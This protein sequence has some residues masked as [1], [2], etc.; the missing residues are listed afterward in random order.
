MGRGLFILMSLKPSTHR[1]DLDTP[2]FVLVDAYIQPLLACRAL[3]LVVQPD[4]RWIRI[5]EQCSSQCF[6]Y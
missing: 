5:G 4:V 1:G 3:R 6:K 2:V